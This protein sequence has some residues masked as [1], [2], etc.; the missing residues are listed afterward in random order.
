MLES[1]KYIHTYTDILKNETLKC[2]KLLRNSSRGRIQSS[3]F[4]K[5]LWAKDKKELGLSLINISSIL[6]LT[7]KSLGGQK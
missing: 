2:K 7:S 4:I 6:T 3:L 5:H 1:R